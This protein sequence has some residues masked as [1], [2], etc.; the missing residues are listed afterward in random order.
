[1]NINFSAVRPLI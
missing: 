1:M